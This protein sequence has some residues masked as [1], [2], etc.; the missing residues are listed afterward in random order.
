MRGGLM[1]LKKCLL[2]I[3]ILILFNISRAAQ[4]SSVE[5]NLSGGQSDNVLIDS[6]QANDFYSTYELKLNLYPSSKIELSLNGDYNYYSN[7][8]F[9]N[10]TNYGA[11][12][13]ILPINRSS[14]FAIYS[15]FKFNNRNYRENSNSVTNN[16]FNTSDYDAL[17]GSS[18][19]FNEMLQIRA[20]VTYHISDFNRDEVANKK[21][22]DLITGFNLT[23]LNSNS[24]DF[25]T[26]YSY[27]NLYYLPEFTTH[28]LFPDMK[29]PY[30]ITRDEQYSLLEKGDIDYFYY[31]IRLS[32]P[33]PLKSGLGLTFSN[34]SFRNTPD[35]GLVYGYSTGYISPWNSAYEG[36][37]IQASIK[38]YILSGIVLNFGGGYWEKSFLRT[39]ELGYDEMLGQHKLIP[40]TVDAAN[41]EENQRKLFLKIEKPM[42]FNTTLIKPFLNLDYTNN[43]SNIVV[44]DYNNFNIIFGVNIKLD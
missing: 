5:L 42:V 19:L 1:F 28:P 37:T 23:F 30:T 33:L 16:N 31:S 8:L 9:L 2:V 4:F 14:K 18:Y 25:E 35:E 12:L 24:L 11:Q 43:N 7:K 13:S 40:T 3:I 10:N 21:N 32:R 34:K 38:S 26:G 36:Y 22:L 17:I 39:L 29:L 6:S 20:L 44:Y 15:N 41:R 27:G